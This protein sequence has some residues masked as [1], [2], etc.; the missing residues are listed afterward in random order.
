MY[1]KISFVIDNG[2]D[3]TSHKCIIVSETEDDALRT[4]QSEIVKKLASN[5]WVVSSETKIKAIKPKN[6]MIYQ[7]VFYEW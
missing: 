6:G 4:F 2:Y 1:F 3:W 5:L 7:D